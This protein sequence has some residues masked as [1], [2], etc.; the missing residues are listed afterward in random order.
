[1]QEETRDLPARAEVDLFNLQVEK[2][3]SDVKKLE[4]KLNHKAGKSQ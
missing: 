3:E 1:M 4:E 2:L